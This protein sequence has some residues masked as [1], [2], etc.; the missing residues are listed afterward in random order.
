[1]KRLA[2]DQKG[3]TAVEYAVLGG[4]IVAA[5]TA[6]QTD[7]TTGLRGAFTALFNSVS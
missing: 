5:I 1:M 2:R 4:V 7:F 6:L 3:L